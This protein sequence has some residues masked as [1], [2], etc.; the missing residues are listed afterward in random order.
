MIKKMERKGTRLKVEERVSTRIS[1]KGL[2]KPFSFLDLIIS[3]CSSDAQVEPMDV[4]LEEKQ[5]EESGETVKAVSVYSMK[6]LSC[7]SGGNIM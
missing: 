6:R 3:Y 1:K 2:F 4:G 7:D 5:S